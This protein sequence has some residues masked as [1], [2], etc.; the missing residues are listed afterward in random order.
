[1]DGQMASDVAE[2]IAFVLHRQSTGAQQTVWS[3]R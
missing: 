2:Y 1:M 3:G